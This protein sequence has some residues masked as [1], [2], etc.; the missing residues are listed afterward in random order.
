MTERPW[1]PVLPGVSVDGAV[2]NEVGL[3]GRAAPDELRAAGADIV[4]ELLR[5]R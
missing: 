1:L 5:E 4:A 2:A 3:T